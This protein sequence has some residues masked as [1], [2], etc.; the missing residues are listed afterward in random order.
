MSRDECA[1]VILFIAPRGPRVPLS[2]SNVITWVGGIIQ[3]C[4]SG[5][6]DDDPL[7]SRLAGDWWKIQG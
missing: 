2:F 7:Q 3:G 4:W 1:G 5:H 6:C